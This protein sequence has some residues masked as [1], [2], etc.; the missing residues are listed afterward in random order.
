MSQAAESFAETQRDAGI[1]EIPMIG[2]IEPG[3]ARRGLASGAVDS[4]SSEEWG[5]LAGGVIDDVRQTDA[6]S[7]SL[8]ICSVKPSRRVCVQGGSVCLN[9]FT[10]THVCGAT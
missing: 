10:M 2:W 9:V 3:T 1:D 8:D 5:P 4:M 6:R 7:L